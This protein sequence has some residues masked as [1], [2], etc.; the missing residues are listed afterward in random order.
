MRTKKQ[1]WEIKR[2]K[3]MCGKWYK[4]AKDEEMA[5]VI[6]GIVLLK[7]SHCRDATFY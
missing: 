2:E 7:K 6:V 3:E 5:C 4:A 1:V